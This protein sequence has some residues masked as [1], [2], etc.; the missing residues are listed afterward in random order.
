[1]D[2][3]RR[4]RRAAGQRKGTVRRRAR[5]HDGIALVA[6]QGR[7][8]GVA[9]DDPRFITA[10]RH[11]LDPGLG[12]GMRRHS[13]YRK[14]RYRYEISHVRLIIADAQ[15]LAESVFDTPYAV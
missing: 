3:T 15:C 13:C 6:F 11:G 10:G 9:G 5:H 14:N 8:N 2:R 7:T 12:L 1:M 4:Y